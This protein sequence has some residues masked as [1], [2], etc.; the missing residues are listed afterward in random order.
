[1]AWKVCPRVNTCCSGN[2][3]CDLHVEQKPCIPTPSRELKDQSVWLSDATPV[4]LAIT[5]SLKQRCAG[6]AEI[7]IPGFGR[8]K[9]PRQSNT[10]LERPGY[11][12]LHSRIGV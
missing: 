6:F 2:A 11:K 12:M 7:G 8:T 3:Y 10:G 1:M 9:P 4:V 5:R